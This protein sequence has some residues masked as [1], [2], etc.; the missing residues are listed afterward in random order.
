[1]FCTM[2]SSGLVTGMMMQLGECLT[3]CSVTEVVIRMLVRR[4][5]SRLIPGRRG[6]AGSNDDDVGTGGLFVAVAASDERVST[7]NGT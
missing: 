1:M 6:N 2:A 5:S 7:Q 3:T 4:R